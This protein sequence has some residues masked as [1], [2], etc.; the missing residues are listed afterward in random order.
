M[1]SLSTFARS[2]FNNQSPEIDTQKAVRMDRRFSTLFTS[3]AAAQPHQPQLTAPPG[4]APAQ[5]QK[6]DCPHAARN[7]SPSPSPS[8]T[9]SRVKMDRR[10]STFLSFPSLSVNTP[11]RTPP[12]S[13]HSETLSLS[14]RKSVRNVKGL[15]RRIF[16]TSNAITCTSNLSFENGEKGEQVPTPE[17]LGDR[18]WADLI[19][20]SRPTTAPLPSPPASRPTT[21]KRTVQRSNTTVIVPAP[22]ST[23]KFK[24]RSRFSQ[25]L[26]GTSTKH[27]DR[28]GADG[29]M[30]VVGILQ[31]S[32][33]KKGFGSG[34]TD[35]KF[36]SITSLPSVHSLSLPSLHEVHLKSKGTIKITPS[37]LHALERGIRRICRGLQHQERLTSHL[38]N[39]LVFLFTRKE[40]QISMLKRMRA[41]DKSHLVSC[42]S[43]IKDSAGRTFLRKAV[44]LQ[45]SQELVTQI[46]EIL[47]K[48]KFEL[49]GEGIDGR[50]VEVEVEV[51]D[52]LFD[53]LALLR[54]DLKTQRELDERLRNM[55]VSESRE[56]RWGGSPGER[57]LLRK[58]VGFVEGRIGALGNAYE[59]VEGLVRGCEGVERL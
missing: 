46:S 42:L 50:E 35:S 30:E 33:K 47:V 4:T 12:Q 17:Q 34:R 5:Q 32:G 18:L 2:Q 57:S 7:A 26:Y 20:Q 11:P 1:V 15:I 13:I 19:G 53:L 23:V 25:A 37:G 28:D 10:F 39:N 52:T 41:D 27:G 22:T 36:S 45:R 31:S 59:N 49:D 48:A 9:T 8:T 54:E 16:S 40:A 29:G 55:L 6:D 43:R 21:P 38:S 3:T 51:E 44:F 24:S 58:F 14:S 56:K